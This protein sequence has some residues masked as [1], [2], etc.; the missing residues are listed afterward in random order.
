MEK[1]KELSINDK[2]LVSFHVD[3]LFTNIILNETIKLAVDLIKTSY[4]NLKISSDNLTKLFKYATCETLFLF[5]EKIYDQIDD[6][7]MGSPLPPV[8]A[9]LSWNITKN[10]GLKTFRGLYHPTIEDM[11]MTFF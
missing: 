11:S 1:L 6:V 7:A 10:S 5:N 4:I 8:L 9:N 2:F 3:S